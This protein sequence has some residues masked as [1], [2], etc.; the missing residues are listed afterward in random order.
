MPIV[1]LSMSEPT[2]KRFDEAAR[3]L[4]YSSRSEAFRD[5]MQDFVSAEEWR[6]PAGRN[7]LIMAV[8]YERD[9][10]KV[11]LS[12]LRHKYEEIRTMLHTHL[13]DVN[14]L[15]VFIAEGVNSR[16]KEIIRHVRRIRGVKQIRF[17]SA[18][19]EV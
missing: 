1:S 17:I 6:L 19:S 2:L 13:D 15:E 16:L 4:G 18:T 14:C 3:R 10:P 11:Q 12:L 8:L 5:A 7:A 9:E